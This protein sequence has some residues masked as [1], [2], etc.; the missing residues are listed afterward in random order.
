MERGKV[1]ARWQRGAAIACGL[2]AFAAAEVA[3]AQGRRGDFEGPRVRP[4]ERIG[5]ATTVP[6]PPAPPPAATPLGGS[7]NPMPGPIPQL[8]DG[9]PGIRPIPGPNPG[10]LSSASPAGAGPAASILAAPATGAAGFAAPS[11]AATPKS[12]AAP[13]RATAG[14]DAG[15]SSGGSTLSARIT[16]IIPPSGAGT[17]GAAAAA[18]RSASPLAADGWASAD[19]CVNVYVRSAK[20]D[21]RDVVSV[22]LHGDGLIKAAAP[23]HLAGPLLA[24]AGPAAGGARAACV[25]PILAQSLFDPL[26]SLA[27]VD[28][29]VRMARVGDRWVLAGS[30]APEPVAKAQP[31]QLAAAT[32]RGAAKKP[33]KKST[34]QAKRAKPAPMQVAKAYFP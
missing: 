12:F 11:R 15:A 29:A 5:V 25:P 18:A 17:P 2:L 26:V 20:I 32:T 13:S 24:R 10:G 28:P 30:R 27:A 34:T 14:S 8:P 22:D 33:A 6:A 7:G 16:E 23:P 31:V 1:T 4:G 21:G 19:P 9:T 3:V